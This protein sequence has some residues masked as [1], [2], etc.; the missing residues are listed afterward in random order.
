MAGLSPLTIRL[1][2][3]NLRLGRLLLTSHTVY[4]P[5]NPTNQ[6]SNHHFNK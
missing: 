1:R 2:E 3:T 5:S 4:Q 6:L